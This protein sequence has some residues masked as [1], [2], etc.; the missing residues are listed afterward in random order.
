MIMN[1][2]YCRM[3]LKVVQLNRC[4]LE[5]GRYHYERL[6]D[7]HEMRSVRIQTWQR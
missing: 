4:L 6:Q 2:V 3:A 1:C 7:E 5:K